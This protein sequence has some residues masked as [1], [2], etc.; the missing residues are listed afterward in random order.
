M[1]KMNEYNIK[2]KDCITTD[3]LDLKTKLVKNI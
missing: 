3:D 2:I 1:E